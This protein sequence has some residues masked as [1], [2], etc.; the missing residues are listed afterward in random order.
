MGLLAQLNEG[1]ELPLPPMPLPNHPV[2]QTLP[3]QHGG[4]DVITRYIPQT[5]PEE[6]AEW[7]HTIPKFNQE[8]AP[9]RAELA[10]D[11]KGLLLRGP[12]GK[13]L[14]LYEQIEAARHG[15]PRI[16]AR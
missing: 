3:L 15:D 6:Y 14:D 12:R 10:S 8:F 2:V 13:V 5:S 9:L 11:G 4:N 1:A 16:M 7:H